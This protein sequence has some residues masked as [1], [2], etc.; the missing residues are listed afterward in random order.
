M[1]FKI[2]ISSVFNESE[3]KQWKSNKIRYFSNSSLTS[4]LFLSKN[5]KVF[6]W[7]SKS[8]FLSF[9]TKVNP[10]NENENE[11]NQTFFHETYSNLTSFFIS[12]KIPKCFN[13]FFNWH[14]SISLQKWAQTIKWNKIKR[15]ICKSDSIFPYLQSSAL[16]KWLLKLI[17]W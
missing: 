2:E 16:F 5:I 9:V 15:G 7:L 4:Y 3:S 17:S 14:F 12:H 6:Q 10:N 11:T 13:D 1:T 8:E